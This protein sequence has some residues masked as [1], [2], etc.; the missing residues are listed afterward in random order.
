MLKSEQASDTTALCALGL[1]VPAFE[2]AL[3][4]AIFYVARQ[5][6]RVLPTTAVSELGLFLLSS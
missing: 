4:Q 2:L 5:L 1:A 3:S 6:G